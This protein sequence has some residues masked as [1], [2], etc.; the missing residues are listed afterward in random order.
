MKLTALLCAVTLALP[1][2]CALAQP[3]TVD[4]VTPLPPNRRPGKAAGAKRAGRPRDMAAKQD[5][6]MIE[7]FETLFARKL[8][9]DEKK[10]FKKAADDRDAAIR[11]AQDGFKA[12]FLK[13]TGVT[14]KELREKR[15]AAR[16]KPEAVPAA[17]PAAAV[18]VAG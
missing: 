10:Q 5:Q 14:E 4:T 17:V 1:L 2:P 16:Q 15:R 3:N 13:I 7:E 6:K 11:A 8:T 9:D 18:P 12:Q